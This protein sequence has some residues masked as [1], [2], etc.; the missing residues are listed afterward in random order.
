MKAIIEIHF[1]PL[2]SIFGLLASYDEVLIEACEN[3]QKGSYRNKTFI[4][5]PGS[6]QLLSVP[7]KKGKHRRSPISE[8][9]IAYDTDWV[10]QHLRSIETAYGAAPFYDYYYPDLKDIYTFKPEGLWEFNK[11]L[12]DF[13]NRKTGNLIRYKFT[14]KYVKSYADIEDLREKYTPRGKGA[15]EP[16]LP[17]GYTYGQVHSEAH[18]FRSTVAVL[19]LLMHRG[20]EAQWKLEEIRSFHLKKR[21]ENKS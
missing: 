6:L 10:T 7:L 5:S 18:G 17:E 13:L 4:A 21:A 8:T 9:Q 20:P 11:E 12:L 14:E 19:D 2:L 1:L 3:Y 15:Q 16:H